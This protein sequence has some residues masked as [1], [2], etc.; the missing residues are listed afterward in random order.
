MKDNE[1]DK[2]RISRM[3]KISSEHKTSAGKC[4]E[5]RPLARHKR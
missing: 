5:K 3:A 4:Q 2:K 1:M